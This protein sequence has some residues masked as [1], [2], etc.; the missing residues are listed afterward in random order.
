MN[1]FNIRELQGILKRRFFNDLVNT[2][3]LLVCYWAARSLRQ[4]VSPDSP[5]GLV[6]GHE[7]SEIGQVLPKRV[8]LRR[9]T[10][11]VS[12]S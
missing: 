3:A 2:T 6:E 11:A 5:G 10:R 9:H 4:G 8:G 12:S 7:V 1:A